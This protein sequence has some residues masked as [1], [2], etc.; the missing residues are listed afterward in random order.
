MLILEKG[1]TRDIFL[2]PRVL[3]A[4]IVQE[5]VFDKVLESSEIIY[6]RQI[7]CRVFYTYQGLFGRTRGRRGDH[8]LL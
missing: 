2:F 7:A 1:Q 4:I 5:K 6:D 3:G 8:I